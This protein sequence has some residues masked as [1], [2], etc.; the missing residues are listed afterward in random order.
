MKKVKHSVSSFASEVKKELTAVPV[1]PKEARA[2]LIAMVHMNGIISLNSEHVTLDI[3]TEN[4][5]IARRIYQA[6]KTVYLIAPDIIVRRKMKLKKNNVYIVRVTMG[7]EGLLKDMGLNL[8]GMMDDTTIE[9]INR[10]EDTMRAYL[11]GAFMAGGSVNNPETSS[12]HLEIYSLQ[13]NNHLILQAM[14]KPFGL[15]VRTAARRNGHFIY[16]KE[17]DKISDFLALIGA[18]Q[19]I[20]KF[21]NVRVT[22]DM[23]NSVNRRV[24]CESANLNKTVNAALQQI[25][26]IQLIQNTMGLEQLSP[27]LQ[28]VARMRMDNPDL[29]LKQLGERLPDG[30][31]SKSGVNHRLRKINA[32]A[33]KIRQVN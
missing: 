4:A 9:A 17:A 29:S 31:V 2:E 26:N 11:R 5:A 18:N 27:K 8:F 1:S 10:S 25:E 33:D 23:R 16:L 22:R 21:E 28:D 30:P 19:S 24:N 14:M 12:Y 6:F 15:N 32:L 20:L 3:Q 7:V 13:E